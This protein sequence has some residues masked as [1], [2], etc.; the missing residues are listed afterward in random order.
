MA[1]RA[2]TPAATIAVPNWNGL[3]YLQRCIDKLRAQT[4]QDLEIV[5]VDNGSSDGSPQWIADQADLVGIFNPTNRGFAAANN[6]ALAAAR[7]PFFVTLNNDTEP[8]PNFL[9][10]LIDALV[11]APELGSAAAVMVWSH[12]PDTIATAGIA[13]HKDGTATDFLAGMPLPTVRTQE[14]FGAS[15]G[16]AAYRVDLLRKVGGFHEAYF[17]YL[18][19][20]DLAWRLRLH[21]YGC[22]VAE[23]AVVRHVYSATSG[24]SSPMKRY[25]LSRNRLM[26]IMRCVPARFLVQ[27]WPYILRY[28]LMAWAEGILRGD[29]PRL[30]GR[31]HAMAQLPKLFS[32]RRDVQAL[33]KTDLDRLEKL[34][35]PPLPWKEALRLHYRPDEPSAHPTYV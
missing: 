27:W 28:E 33:C 4:V 16:A 18:E 32:E 10:A 25:L 17:A 9:E 23:R 20:A 35:Q 12:R 6:Q 7:S 2:R 19:D 29:W 30:R 11:S 34:V 22:L 13:F 21:R 5:V 1:S 3:P 8:E 15:A 26:L 31:L 24:R 14:V